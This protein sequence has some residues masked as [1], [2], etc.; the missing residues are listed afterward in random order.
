MFGICNPYLFATNFGGCFQISS[1]PSYFTPY[2]AFA[3][4]NITNPFFYSLNSCCQSNPAQ[5]YLNQAAYSQGQQIGDA[6]GVNAS[7]QNFA[8]N[9]E[10][11]K[12]TLKEACESDEIKDSYKQQLKATLKEVEKIE[13]EFTNLKQLQQSADSQLI[14]AGLDVIVNKFNGL[15]EKTQALTDKILAENDAEQNTQNPEDPEEPDKPTLEKPSALALKDFTHKLDRAIYGA[16]TNYDSDENGLK[17]LMEQI[18]AGSVLEVWNQWDNTYGTQ[19]RYAK[20][21]YGFI[22]TLMDDCE[23]DQKEEIGTYLIDALEER[24]Y[25]LGIDADKEVSEARLSLKSNWIGW[26]NDDKICKAMIALKNK[27]E[28]TQKAE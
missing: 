12:A 2:E 21:D 25:L 23:G 6:I 18:D 1:M 10:S 15:K 26:R 3:V 16:R 28:Q 27:V 17:P 13:Q 24:A 19:G 7:M 11:F 22:E 9:I 20:D 14:K 5:N 8:N 4:Q